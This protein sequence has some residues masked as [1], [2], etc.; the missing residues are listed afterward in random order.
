MLKKYFNQ[1][2]IYKN[3]WNKDNSIL[4]FYLKS[5]KVCEYI[6]I[7]LIQLKFNKNIFKNVFN[8]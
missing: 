1:L 8:P 5:D 6:I 2:E 7:N 3:T 4:H